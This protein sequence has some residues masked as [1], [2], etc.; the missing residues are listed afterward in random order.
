MLLR[1]AVLEDDLL[2]W[3]EMGTVMDRAGKFYGEFVYNQG[4]SMMVY[5]HQQYGPEKVD[6]LTRHVGSMNFD[7]AIREVLGISADQFYDDWQAFLTEN[8]HRLESEI[9][10]GAWILAPSD[11]D[12]FF[13]NTPETIWR[14][15]LYALG[16]KYRSISLLPEDPAVN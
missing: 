9:G 14:E 13:T 5:I 11:P 7:P 15:T 12:L 10:S 3:S 16:G 8:Y 1:M 6:A 2:S 4:Y